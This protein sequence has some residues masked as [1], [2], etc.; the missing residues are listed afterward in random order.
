MSETAV[1]ERKPKEQRGPKRKSEFDSR[2][3]PPTQKDTITLPQLDEKVTRVGDII[4]PE[5][6]LVKAQA[7]ALLF[8]EEPVTILFHQSGERFAAKCT[9]LIAVNGQKAPILFS[10]GWVPVGYLPRGVPFITKRKFLE[11][12]ARSKETKYTTNV[13]K[14]DDITRPYENHVTPYTSALVMF[15]IL[16]DKNP[17]GAEWLTQLLRQM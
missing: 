5:T 11:V 2:S 17:N 13:I 6:P 12:M 4:I 10:N 3:V 15:S 9:D 14:H 8:S 1:L 16:E 7:D